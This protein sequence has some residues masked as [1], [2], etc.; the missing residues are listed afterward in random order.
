MTTITIT[1]TE[2]QVKG[3]EF[4]GADPQEWAENVVTSRARKAVDEI[5]KIYTTCALDE[6]VSIPAT[7]EEIVTDAYAR[8]W[9][10]NPSDV[11]TH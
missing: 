1:L 7:R 8:G 11:E 10:Q 4:V 9:V 5:V 6:G 3:L 2:T